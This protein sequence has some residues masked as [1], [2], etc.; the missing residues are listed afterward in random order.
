MKTLTDIRSSIPQSPTELTEALRSEYVTKLRQL[1]KLGVISDDKFQVLV[2]AFGK[3]DLGD[4]SKVEREVLLT[5]F[6]SLM[7]FV[8]D[9]K[10]LF[11]KVRQQGRAAQQHEALTEAFRP[12]SKSELGY[13]D[14]EYE[15]VVHDRLEK[16]GYK[17]TSDGQYKHKDSGKE[18]VVI[19]HDGKVHHTMVSESTFPDDRDAP[20]QK[21]A[22]PVLILLRRKAIRLF[23]DGK[24]V[25][26]YY[27]DKLKRYISIPS[28][29]DAVSEDMLQEAAAPTKSKGSPKTTGAGNTFTASPGG[30]HSTQVMAALKG[31][32]ANRQPAQVQFKCG[33]KLKVDM[34][35]AHAILTVYG[36]LS[37]PE[38]QVKFD[39]MLNKDNAGFMK[40]LDFVH[41]HYISNGQ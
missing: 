17:K 5:S 40:I 8:L 22:F 36:R 38:N 34:L 11:Q 19:R 26:L 20:K 6:E 15:D 39:K 32:V 16:A 27:A 21:F 10:Q 18:V 24:K 29:G 35:T 1:G 7:H 23:P 3:N 4:L 41:K 13:N 2:R 31:I 12:K 33:S 25:G 37:N 30:E 14:G 9:N 28:T